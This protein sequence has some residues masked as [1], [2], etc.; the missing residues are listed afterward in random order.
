[1]RARHRFFYRAGAVIK[2]RA[3]IN[4]IQ[5]DTDHFYVKAIGANKAVYL[6]GQKFIYMQIN[7]A[8]KAYL[9][10]TELV[11]YGDVI[12][13]ADGTK[14]FGSAAKQIKQVFTKNSIETPLCFQATLNAD[15]TA[16]NQTINLPHTV[17]TVKYRP[18]FQTITDAVDNTIVVE[19]VDGSQ[20][21]GQFDVYA[22]DAATGNSID[23]SVNNKK[24]D[25][26]IQFYP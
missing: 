14:N 22:K 3:D 23:L 24:I 20:A 4:T 8:T 12:P 9:S 19:L 1:M 16:G 26:Q 11:P 13:Q 5:H 6:D 18:V 10:G 25:I 2:L 7:G 15:F 21:V 17:P